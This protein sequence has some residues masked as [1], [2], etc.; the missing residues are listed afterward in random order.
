[1][2]RDAIRA[3]AKL[4]VGLR[5]LG[6]RPDG[7]HE[8]DSPMVA[9]DLHDDL[10]VHAEG[11]RDELVRIPSGDAAIDAAPMPLDGTNLVL[12]ALDAYRRAALSAGDTPPPPLRIELCKRV[13]L[14]AGLG[15][16]SSDAAAALRLCAARWPAQPDLAVLAAAIGSD[17]PFFLADRTWAR[18]RGRGERLEIL[19]EQALVAVL[20]NPG[21]GVSAADAYRWWSEGVGARDA[22][23]ASW[24][25]LDLTND[26]EPGVAAHVPEVAEVLAWLRAATAAPVAMSGSGA[27]CFALTEDPAEA[28]DLAR[29]ARRDGRWWSRVVRDASRLG[30]RG[31]S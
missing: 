17:V 30:V 28:D 3:P 21:V 20:V 2:T 31:P 13:P 26:L 14:A 12:R 24:R 6:R 5:V 10:V 22:S 19:S 11:E 16:G 15:G 1:M 29:R 9:I 4:N 18:A 7:F 27:T 23:R 25:G 8:I